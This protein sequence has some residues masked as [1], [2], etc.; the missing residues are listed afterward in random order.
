MTQCNFPC[1]PLWR[2]WLILKTQFIHQTSLTVLS[3]YASI[4]KRTVSNTAAILSDSRKA[5]RAVCRLLLPWGTVQQSEE[6]TCCPAKTKTPLS[7]AAW[8]GWR[9]CSPVQIWACNS[10]QNFRLLLISFI[11][12]HTGL[13][14]W[15]PLRLHSRPKTEALSQILQGSSCFTVVLF[16]RGIKPKHG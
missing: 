1:C 4:L 5:H 13:T 7:S 15:R 10:Q 2:A 3:H 8:W 6:K 12:A 16:I 9:M 14:L 11:L